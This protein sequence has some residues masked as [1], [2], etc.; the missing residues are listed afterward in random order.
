MPNYSPIRR[1]P[2]TTQTGEEKSLQSE[3]VHLKVLGIDYFIDKIQY[4]TNTILLEDTVYNFMPTT[5]LLSCKAL[6]SQ[7]CQTLVKTLTLPSGRLA[8]PCAPHK[9]RTEVKLYQMRTPLTVQMSETVEFPYSLFSI[10][11]IKQNEQ[12]KQCIPI[13]HM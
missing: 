6:K 4:K 11:I 10:K 12:T 1:P 5:K 2:A 9:H 13:F 7:S 8:Q 3:T